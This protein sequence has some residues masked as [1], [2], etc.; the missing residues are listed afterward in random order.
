MVGYGAGLRGE[1]GHG[2]AG[3]GSASS[4]GSNHFGDYL[5][6]CSDGAVLCGIE[7]VWAIPLE[8]RG[9]LSRW[10]LMQ[11]LLLCSSLCRHGLIVEDGDVILLADTRH[12]PVL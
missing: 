8:R 11:E 12:T 9:I 2:Y 10:I 5:N 1:L 6:L 4:N 7:G 3:C